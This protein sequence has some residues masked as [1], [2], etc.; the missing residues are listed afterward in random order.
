MAAAKL[1][2][3]C[4]TNYPVRVIRRQPPEEDDADCRLM[5]K[6]KYHYSIRISPKL[7]GR[8]AVWAL[9]HEWAHAMSWPIHHG[10][11]PLHGA[12]FGV[13]YAEAYT[14]IYDDEE[15]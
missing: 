2:H 7:T 12:F 14:A 15:I 3:F 4:P 9:V 10:R 5:T 13:A 11:H 8:F 1:R 6:G